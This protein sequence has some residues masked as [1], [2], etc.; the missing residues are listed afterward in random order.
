MEYTLLAFTYSFEHE[1]DLQDK[2]TGLFNNSP[3]DSY[4]ETFAHLLDEN[5]L[6]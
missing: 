2:K 6:R 1:Q 3:L 5:W 4:R